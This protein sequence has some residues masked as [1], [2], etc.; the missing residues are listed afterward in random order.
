MVGKMKRKR[1][2]K[3]S[4]TTKQQNSSTTPTHTFTN[5]PT[6]YHH[7]PPFFEHEMATVVQAHSRLLVTA[8]ASFSVSFWIGRSSPKIFG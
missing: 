8:I 5:Q 6:Y 1:G 7:L 3:A 4:K 2:K